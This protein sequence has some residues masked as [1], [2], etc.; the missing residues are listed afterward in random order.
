M[1]KHSLCLQVGLSLCDAGNPSASPVSCLSIKVN[2]STTS[3]GH[4]TV[5]SG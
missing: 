5:G 1:V 2:I 3:V 4:R